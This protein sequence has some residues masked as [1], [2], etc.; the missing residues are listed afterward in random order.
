MW[1][2]EAYVLPGGPRPVNALWLFVEVDDE[3]LVVVQASAT[4]TGVPGT[5]SSPLIQEDLLIE[6]VEEHLR[7]YPE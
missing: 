7:P 3:T 2:G 4:S 1:R 5:D 6:V